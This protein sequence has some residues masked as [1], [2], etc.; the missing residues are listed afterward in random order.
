MNNIELRKAQQNLRGLQLNYMVNE[1]RE[2]YIEYNDNNVYK[3]SRFSTEGGFVR[4]LIRM[5]S[6]TDR[7][8]VLS[9]SK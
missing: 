1:R 9:T 7:Y 8:V 4:A 6:D 3:V 5:Y 2:S